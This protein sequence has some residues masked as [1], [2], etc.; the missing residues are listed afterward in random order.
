MARNEQLIRQ[1]RLLQI[2]ERRRYGSTLDE[3][4]ESIV[5]ELG[6]TSL[7]PR[8]TRRDLEALLAAGFDISSEDSPRGKLWRM[9]REDRGLHRIH[10]SASELIALS[11]GRDL[12]LPLVGTPFWHGIESFWNKVREQ[13]PD[14]VWEHYQ[15]YRRHLHVLG[16]PA[17]TYEKQQG[18]LRNI[19]R[20]IQEHRQVE[21]EYQS[22]G[23]PTSRRIIEP[24]GLVIYQSSIYVVAT[25]AREHPTHHPAEPDATSDRIRHWKLDR[26]EKAH[27]LDAW[28]KPDPQLDLDQHLG[29]SVGIF[30][31]GQLETYRVRL[32]AAAAGWVKEDPWHPNQQLDPLEN[33]EWVLTVPAFHPLEILAKV[34]PLGT[35]AEVLS[36]NSCRE[37]L[38]AIAQQLAS[39]YRQPVEPQAGS[40]GGGHGQIDEA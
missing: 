25:E 3:L 26:F 39:R 31:G 10:A 23:K 36:P 28:F 17:K 34:L 11:M 15:R 21:I 13:L 16:V 18:I 5:D 12:L 8:S 37:E 4:T 38:A 2:L 40:T 30:S 35:E 14:G 7:H 20:A 19:N 33:G 27:A 6:L 22:V 9:R 1:H 29:Q 24:Y 32:S